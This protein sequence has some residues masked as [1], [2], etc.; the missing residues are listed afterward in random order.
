MER[1]LNASTLRIVLVITL[2]LLVTGGIVG[3]L[4][5]RQELIKSA[6]ETAKVSAVAST[7]QSS[8]NVLK[9]E[10]S[11]LT[12]NK[13]VEE[14]VRKMVATGLK[15]TYQDQI[16]ESLQALAGTTGVKINNINFQAATSLG[17]PTAAAPTAGVATPTVVPGGVTLTQA[18]VTLATPV[19]YDSLV[20]FVRA[21]EQ[22]TM[23]MKVSKLTISATSDDKDSKQMVNC[24]ML[25]IGVYMR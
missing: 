10:L 9:K 20:R 3:F 22:N 25:T 4:Y 1:K 12:A 21:I 11:D 8:V 2:L 17:A 7:S 5:V 16:V 24:D 15:Y 23:T 19:R 6:I 13:D 14:K 18:T